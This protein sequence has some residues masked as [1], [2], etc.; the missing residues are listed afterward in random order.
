MISD[1]LETQPY[2]QL[3]CEPV[4]VN[5][6][7]LDNDKDGNSMELVNDTGVENESR[8]EKILL[9]SQNNFCDSSSKNEVSGMTHDL[10][11]NY[12][13]NELNQYKNL[14]DEKNQLIQTLNEKNEELMEKLSSLENKL[15]KISG[16][17][18]LLKIKENLEN[19][20]TE[21]APEN[22]EDSN[23]ELT[24]STNLTNRSNGSNGSNDK[25]NTSNVIIE[26]DPKSKEK[27]IIMEPTEK[28]KIKKRPNMLGTRF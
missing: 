22:E 4:N 20:K 11:Y 26:L 18:L 2:V 12:F 13:I 27:N 15:T 9:K 23:G 21:L 28:T 3:I 7:T 19:K 10:L 6:E 14:I 5:K 17:N 8:L 1:I 25:S 24:Q 16:V